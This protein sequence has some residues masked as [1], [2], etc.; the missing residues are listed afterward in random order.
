MKY[1]CNYQIPVDNSEGRYYAIS[2]CDK[3]AYIHSVLVRLGYDIEIISPSFAKKCSKRRTDRINEH[4]VITS[5]FSLGWKGPLSRN[6]SRI[7]SMLW[8]L[9]YL[10]CECKRHE[11]IMIYHNVQ[12]IPIFIFA[13]ALK[14]FHYI[15]EVEELFSYLRPSA[16]WR[17]SLEKSIIRRTD[18]FVF[19]SH[20]L[21]HIC[22]VYGK[23]YLICNGC[24]AVPSTN[25]SDYKKID[26]RVHIVYAGLIENGRVAFKSVDIARYLDEN[27]CIHIIGY[28]KDADIN[29]LKR[30]IASVNSNSKCTVVYDGL[31]RGRDYVS[32]M[33]KCQIGIC[34]LS[35]DV[36]YQTACFPSKII[37]YLCNNLYVVS[38]YNEVLKDSLF[39]RYIHFA[40]TDTPFS[41]AKAIR[42]IDLTVPDNPQ[43]LIILE[44]KR[45][46]DEMGGLLNSKKRG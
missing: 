41:F 28:G 21:E 1:I 38:T 22:N 9:K 3:A 12:N 31:K 5:C 42:E 24:F 10:L 6:I 32:Y 16:K 34:P 43:D 15:L 30:S 23:P 46:L 7:S 45:V 29:N 19:A 18:K 36:T 14:H 44:D 20:Q 17:L 25:M 27:Y 4:V 8:L 2:A 26:D 11:T 13:Y 39:G 33:H 40:S 35:S 37:S